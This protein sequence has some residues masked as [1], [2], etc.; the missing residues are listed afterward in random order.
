[1]QFEG[2][3]VREQGVTFAVV[4]VKPH[5]LNSQSESGRVAAGFQPA[6][7]GTPIV[8]MAQNHRG[9]PT[10]M[11]RRDLVNFLSRVP[12]NAIPWKRYSLN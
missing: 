12:V 5:V 4:I 10:Y 6:F 11:G 3:L 2:A 7:P 8:L 9:A 1:M